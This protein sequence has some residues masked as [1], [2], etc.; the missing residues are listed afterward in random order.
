MIR[1]DIAGKAALITGA[2]SGIGYAAAQL[3]GSCGA[4]VVL[5]DIVPQE[6]LD[7]AASRLHQDG[8]EATPAR[9]DT[10]CEEDIVRTIDI[11]V[12]TYGRIDYLI[13]N[14]GTSATP[15][16]IPLPD[17]D[18]ISDEIWDAILKTN[19]LGPFRFAR[20][21]SP[22]LKKAAGAIVNTS[23]AAAFTVAGSSLAYSASKAA[24]VKLTRD[25][26][27]ALGPDVRVNAVAPGFIK[28]SWTARFS[29]EWERRGI[30]QTT[31]KRAGQ[32]EDVAELMLYLCAGAA[33]MTGQTILI[34]GGVL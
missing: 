13:C 30:E 2:A 6:T 17:L 15:K 28:T 18:A 34:D 19:L 29:P 7:Q 24:L 16:P 8:I 12:Q 25:L 20:A 31:L 21:A 22:H 33:F 4:A 23:S 3:F 1:A 10:G 27:I 11:A 5:A 32:P 26:A 14:A 9:A